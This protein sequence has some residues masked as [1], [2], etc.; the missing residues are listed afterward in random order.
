MA[1]T[2]T[3][4]TATATATITTTTTTTLILGIPVSQLRVVRDELASLYGES[5]LQDFHMSS[6]GLLDDHVMSGLRRFD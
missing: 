1:T 3:T 4:T 5:D 6:F 2:A